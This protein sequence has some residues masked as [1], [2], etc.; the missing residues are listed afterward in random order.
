MRIVLFLTNSTL[1]RVIGS[2]QDTFVLMT[3]KIYDLLS[4]FFTMKR[5]VIF[6]G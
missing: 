2:L 5:N 4:L 3:F 1:S 6:E